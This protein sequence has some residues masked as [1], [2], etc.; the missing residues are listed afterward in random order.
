MA[1]L[2]KTIKKFIDEYSVIIIIIIAIGLFYFLNNYNRNKGATFENYSQSTGYRGYT[3]V[4]ESSNNSKNNSR[5]NSRN[6]GNN[7]G[8]SPSASKP[9]GYNETSMTVSGIKTNM[10]G[11]KPKDCNIEKMIDP[12]ELL[13]LDKGKYFNN[14]NP[15]GNGDLRNVNLITGAEKIGMASQVL[16]NANLQ[17][18][19]EPPN[20]INK[21]GPWMQT[22]IEPDLHRRPL[23]GS[24]KA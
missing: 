20:P 24:C 10:G 2:Q 5:N 23:D 22:T 17:L 4:G 15:N 18:R 14:M 9:L 13:P 6:N 16:R 21:V 19:C 12:S 3:N 1:K 11:I 7:S 8:R